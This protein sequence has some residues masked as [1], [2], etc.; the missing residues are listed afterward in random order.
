MGGIRLGKGVASV[1]LMGA[2]ILGSIPALAAD[3]A[4]PTIAEAD[5]ELPKISDEVRLIRALA[6]YRSGRLDLAFPVW[7]KMAKEGNKEAA[8]VLR[9]LA[10]LHPVPE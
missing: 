7:E 5:Q 4:P 6:M 1:A 9:V 2:L 3:T 8:Y 10:P